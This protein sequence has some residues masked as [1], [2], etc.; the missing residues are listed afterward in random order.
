[1]K[2]ILIV[3]DLPAH[4]D[5]F[6]VI[7]QRADC[8]L[9]RAGDGVSALRAVR[10]EKPDLIFLD[11]EMPEMNGGEVCRMIRADP[12]S[13]S[14]PVV[15]V[16]SHH[17]PEFA[18]K[19]GANEF[20]R[21]PV[22]EPVLLGAL[23]KYLQLHAR[24]E[25][26]LTVEWP[27][28]FWR[29]GNSHHGRMLDLSRSGFFLEAAPLQSIGVRLAI[30]FAI[31]RAGDGDRS[32]VGEAIVVRWE[33]VNRQGMGCRFFRPTQ[34]GTTTLENYLSVPDAES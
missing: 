14:I 4:L 18:E 13:E 11:I 7:L 22:E 5:L 20:L 28:T 29:E 8:R 25:Q 26:R 32:F 6:E 1:M 15:L 9:L 17:G 2:K 19:C 31:P 3:D 16:S 10:E 23:A 30:S 34:T 12:L 21:K 24:G 27:I 33:S